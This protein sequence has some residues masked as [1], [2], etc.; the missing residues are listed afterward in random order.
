MGMH[1]STPSKSAH[2]SVSDGVCGTLHALFPLF[3]R[4]APEV[5]VI[6]Y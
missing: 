3:S 6:I 2:V 4:H 1:L 5:C